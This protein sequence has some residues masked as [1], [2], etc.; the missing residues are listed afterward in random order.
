M[1]IKTELAGFDLE[2][3][4]LHELIRNKIETERL[5]RISLS[6]VTTEHALIDDDHA[7]KLGAS[8]KQKRGQITPIA[9][10]ARLD[11][12]S[13]EIVY[14]VIDGFHRTEGKKRTGAKDINAT[15]IYGCSDE[16]MY[17]L[18]ILAASSVRS[19]QFARVAQW[20]TDSF[21]TTRWAEKGL[22]VSQAFGIVVSN[23]LNPYLVKLGTEELWQLREWV[24]AK[25]ERWGK[26]PASTYQLLRLVANADPGLV[27]EVRTATGGHSRET[28]ITQA[29]L[30]L[31]VNEHPGKK[32]YTIQRAILH[33]SIREKL[34]IDEIGNIVQQ[35]RGKITTGMDE[36]AVGRVIQTTKTTAHQVFPPPLKEEATK[37]QELEV[38][39]D[40]DPDWDDLEPTDEEIE[41]IEQNGKVVKAKREG[42]ILPNVGAYARGEKDDVVSLRERIK[43]LEEKLEYANNNRGMK[44]TDTWWRS[45]P[46]LTVGEKVCLE[47]V[48]YA[49]EDL[50]VLSLEIKES[51]P[52]IFLLIRSGFAK[53]HLLEVR[54]VPAF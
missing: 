38:E 29:K 30:E 10:R 39:D 8:M 23:T 31:V 37:E 5:E 18:R 54:R 45:A 50:S 35:L 33:H 51:I 25:C 52:R 36:N 34:K 14:D 12:E 15:V 4:S 32:N 21:A 2:S 47:R 20:M 28:T 42:G 11:D 9:V 17:D 48:L 19:V 41:A 46:Y 49:N 6:K 26:T 24:R 16:E 44:S 22:S 43:D 3:A 1:P 40:L 7:D 13:G 53:R 27:R